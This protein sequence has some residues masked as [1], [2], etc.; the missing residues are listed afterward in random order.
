MRT[1]NYVPVVSTV[2]SISV[3]MSV[4]V[5]AAAV[6][7][8]EA[9]APPT[10]VITSAPTTDGKAEPAAIT[11]N[12]IP[13]PPAAEPPA[14][15]PVAVPQATA[16]PP[17][18]T[19]PKPVLSAKEQKRLRDE[20]IYRTSLGRAADV[21]ILIEKGVSADEVNDTKTPLIS[22]ASSRSDAQALDIVKVLLE[23]GADLN[24][25]DSRGRNALIYAA[26]SGNKAVVEYLL[27]K[28]IK[29]AA[30]DNSGSNARSIAYQTGNIE[31]VEMLD[32]F[33]RG[34]ND[35]ARKESDKINKEI[36][37]KIKI[38]NDK[39]KEQI[40]NE[41]DEQNKI[42][43]AASKTGAIQ[44]AV[45]DLAFSSCSASY[46]E[47]C[48]T[49]GQQTQFG[50]KEII[51]YINSLNTRANEHANDL[52]KTYYVKKDI[53]ENIMTVSSDTI[54]AQLSEYE[55]NVARTDDGVGTVED[56]NRRCNLIADTWQATPKKK[57]K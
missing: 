57:D 46:W 10:P 25:V 29:F 53:V 21:K 50:A 47:F 7:A 30:V 4:L 33:V 18:Q 36:A 35:V 3:S 1:L 51:G 49:Y 22:L 17:V 5:Y 38:Y 39:I 56:M 43:F 16:Q 8:Q 2:F 27:S 23:A 32:N 13:A 31:I 20:I 15:V 54:K 41:T 52:I 24:K 28:K 40:K 45:H 34:Q 26:K 9:A 55:T 14:S 6:F 42:K 19:A 44:M 12:Q 37:D 48:N 11:P